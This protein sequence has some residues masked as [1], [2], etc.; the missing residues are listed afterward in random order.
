MTTAA[1]PPV[2][3]L[4]S[5]ENLLD[6]DILRHSGTLCVVGRGFTMTVEY[7]ALAISQGSKLSF[8]ARPGVWMPWSGGENP[9]PGMKVRVKWHFPTSRTNPIAASGAMPSNDVMWDDNDIVEYMVISDAAQP[10]QPD[11][12]PLAPVRGDAAYDGKTPVL[13]DGRVTYPLT[14]KRGDPVEPPFGS[15][16]S[17]SSENPAKIEISPHSVQDG[18]R[19]RFV[20][21]G[22][23][24]NG[25][26]DWDGFTRNFIQKAADRFGDRANIEL[27]E[28]PEKPLAV[29]DSVN[30][31]D[32]S[33]IMNGEILC[34]CNDQAWVKEYDGLATTVLLSNLTRA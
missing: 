32:A 4:T 25:S 31:D 23:V 15:R 6:G 9:V 2:G 28:R 27:L 17:L 30:S 18:D 33:R 12:A 16:E 22:V 34:I 19:I 13:K 21:E 10:V 8:V 26:G 11:A 24:G 20:I 3:P 5:T 29:G 14:T 1:M 7:L